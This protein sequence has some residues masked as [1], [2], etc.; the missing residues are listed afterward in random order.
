[1]KNVVTPIL[2]Y[3]KGIF[4][5]Q[6]VIFCGEMI[7]GVIL[8]Q[9]NPLFVSPLA[10]FLKENGFRSPSKRLSPILRTLINFIQSKA[11]GI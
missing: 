6:K 11:R 3:T 2:N 1:M 10:K 5:L 7:H 8:M 4:N 9:F